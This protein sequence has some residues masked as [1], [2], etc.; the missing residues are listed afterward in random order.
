MK[1]DTM[2]A[3]IMEQET[4][5]PERDNAICSL[6][7]SNLLIAGS[8]YVAEGDESP[9]TPT[10][11]YSE[12]IMVCPNHKCLNWAGVDHSNPKKVDKVLRR[13]AND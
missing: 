6:C 12:L 13:K 4:L 9:I 7:G 8:R 10:I 5:K 2:E 11:I 3:P 1:I